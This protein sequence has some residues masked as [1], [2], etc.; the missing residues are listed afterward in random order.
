MPESRVFISVDFEGLPLVSNFSHLSPGKPGYADA[1]R[2]LSRILTTVVNKL[3]DMGFEVTI[4]DSHGFMTN[5]DW[6]E[7]SP[8]TRLIHGYPRPHSMVYGAR[9]SAFAILLGYHGGAGA[10][11]VLSH[12]YSIRAIHSIRIG[13]TE[14]SE[15]LMNAL[16]LGEMGV[17]V[18][19]VA[20][21]AELREEVEKYTPQAVFIELKRSIS[22]TAAES[23]PPR[24]VEEELIK[25]IENVV[26]LYKMGE[27]K[28]LKPWSTEF[29]VEFSL[30][31]YADLVSLIPGVKRVDGRRI[32]YNLNSIVKGIDLLEVIVAVCAGVDVIMSGR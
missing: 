18:G 7:L 6:C 12:T 2:V 20:G 23:K 8:K 32:R 5:V 30:P 13:G 21:S 16:A 14:V 19:L 27:L 10:A 1:R 31:A 3:V 15:F 4:A 25:A 24:E 26:E 22:Y 9:G 28:P 29:E 17:P 11:S